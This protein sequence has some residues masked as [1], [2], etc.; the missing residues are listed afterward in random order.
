M[1]TIR[2]QGL[3]ERTPVRHLG[4]HLKFL[5]EFSSYFLRYYTVL[6]YLHPHL[7]G[8]KSGNKHVTL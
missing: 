8:D 4:T 7:G 2:S 5:E 6:S 3:D 1:T